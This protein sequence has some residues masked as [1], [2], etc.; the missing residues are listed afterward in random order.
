[1]RVKAPLVAT[2]RMPS[3]TT[4]KNKCRKEC[5]EFLRR[6]APVALLKWRGETD[7]GYRRNLFKT[8]NLLNLTCSLDV[9]R[10]IRSHY[11]PG[12]KC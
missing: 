5:Y 8:V 3:T 9:H 2:G 12:Y 7:V 10:I 1:M 4:C 11:A 6:F